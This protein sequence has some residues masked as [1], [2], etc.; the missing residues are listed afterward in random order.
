[1][2]TPKPAIGAALV[3]VVWHSCPISDEHPFNV[4]ADHSE[5]HDYQ[6]PAEPATGYLLSAPPSSD[7]RVPFLPPD[8]TGNLTA[9]RGWN[10]QRVRQTM[11]AAMMPSS[12]RLLLA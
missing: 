3:A 7:R 5:I 8:D 12:S 2:K 6:A 1:M 10:H 11:I 9:L 4:P